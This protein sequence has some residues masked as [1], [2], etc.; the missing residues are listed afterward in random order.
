MIPG[1]VPIYPKNCN[2]GN[3]Y[4]AM[5]AEELTQKIWNDLKSYGVFVL[6]LQRL[7]TL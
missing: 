3:Q 4:A 6:T 1:Y 7:Q 2:P 5:N